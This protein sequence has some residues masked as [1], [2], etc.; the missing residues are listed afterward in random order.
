MNYQPYFRLEPSFLDDFTKTLI[1][2]TT[3]PMRFTQGLVKENDDVDFYYG[4]C[5][6]YFWDLIGDVFNVKLLR[7]NSN[8]AIEQRKSILSKHSMGLI[9]IVNEFER[10]EKNASDANI[11]VLKYSDLIA[12]LEKNKN[13][14]KIFF[15]GGA[16]ESMVSK[17][18]GQNKIYN[19]VISKDSPK[20]KVFLIQERK[21]NSFTLFSPSPRVIAV[22]SYDTILKQYKT[23][24]SDF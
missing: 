5:D 6:N 20:Q 16:T 11:N 7:E 15:T 14:S 23:F 22:K 24:L 17:Y 3:P 13:I 2:G 10:K 4:S 18:L 19:T 9:D 21:I 12:I 1:I 8:L